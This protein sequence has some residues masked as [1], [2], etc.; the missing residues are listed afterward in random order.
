MFIID[1]DGLGGG[2]GGATNPAPGSI[3]VRSI[4]RP[5][6]RR[7]SHGINITLAIIAERELLQRGRTKRRSDVM[8]EINRATRVT[9]KS[10]RNQL[11]SSST[12]SQLALT[13]DRTKARYWPSEAIK[14][15]VA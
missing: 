9:G 15:V 8:V 7:T 11:N 10:K 3:L 14:T 5:P 4:P 2:F 6:T 12:G 13:G 1:G